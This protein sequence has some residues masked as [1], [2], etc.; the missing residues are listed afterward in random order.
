VPPGQVRPEGGTE[1]VDAIPSGRSYY[2]GLLEALTVIMGCANRYLRDHGPRVATLA[3]RLGREMGMSDQECARLFIAAVLSDL[4]M[5]GLAEDAWERPAPSLAPSVRAR[6]R[7]HPQRSAACVAKIP[8]LGDLA[9]LVR[10]HHE[11]WN[12]CGYPDELM[13]RFMPKGAA[14]L[15]LADTVC[16]LSEDRPY[17]PALD[18]AAIAATVRRGSGSEFAPDV[19]RAYLALPAAP[20][21]AAFDREA[22]REALGRATA[23][24]VPERVS[25]LSAKQML[26]ILADLIDAKDPYTG[27]HSRRVA[28]LSVAIAEQIGLM[29]SAKDLL[30]AGGYLH[31]LGKLRVPLRVLTKE[32]RLTD[33]EFALI[34]LHPVLGAD[35]L[36]TIPTL[37]HLS[38]GVRYHHER[39]D[40]RG[41]PAGL[42]GD[43]IP[44]VA[45]ILAVSDAYDAMISS[46][47]Y[48][49][50]RAPADAMEEVAR[51]AGVHF[52]PEVVEAFFEVPGE[53][54]AALH[55]DRPVTPTFV[56]DAQRRRDTTVF[57]GTEVLRFH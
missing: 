40:G 4:G 35:L 7:A 52:C 27:G 48:R 8:H 5:I 10:S 30:W 45:R 54:F 3:S 9:P 12:G 26:R 51:S 19:V 46:R 23:H 17:R 37:W 14:V 25:P 49:S 1:V 18:R 21:V 20:D 28:G 50:A 32:G 43:K 13:G 34:R 53:T 6:V 47:A 57:D 29:G 11:W 56:A 41:Y 31:D 15:R 22:Y 36:G 44:L 38:T 2:A 33:E 24:L 16:A 42:R 39:W 55:A